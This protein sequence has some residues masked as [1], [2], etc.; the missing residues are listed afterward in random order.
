MLSCATHP[1][2]KTA[3]RE[4]KSDKKKEERIGAQLVAEI[5]GA[6]TDTVTQQHLQFLILYGDLQA[7]IYNRRGR[8]SRATAVVTM[9][10]ITRAP[11]QS[12]FRPSCN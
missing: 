4:E 11:L 8:R 5:M 10:A 6:P 12:I 2:P 9:V 7:Y 1:N 3:R